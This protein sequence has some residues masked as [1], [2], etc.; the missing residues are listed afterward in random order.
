MH[1]TNHHKESQKIAYLTMLFLIVWSSFMFFGIR[2]MID[3]LFMGLLVMS[4][5]GLWAIVLYIPFIL[6]SLLFISPFYLLFKK[7]Y[8]V[9]VYNSKSS[10]PDKIN[11]F[12][13]FILYY[14]IPL[15]F[16]T[17][18]SN[19]VLGNYELKYQNITT[20]YFII[21]LPIIVIFILDYIYKVT[22][23]KK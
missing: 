18:I 1:K 20:K 15:L 7:I 4:E 2:L 14:G 23:R 19:Q 9:I 8:R 16:A 22:L 3:M 21:V 5:F 13:S 17:V 12:I 6:I 10:K 11:L